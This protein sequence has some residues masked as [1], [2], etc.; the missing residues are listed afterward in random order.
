MFQHLGNVAGHI[1]MNGLG[2]LNKLFRAPFGR[3]AMLRGQ[4]L[5]VCAVTVLNTDTWMSCDLSILVID[6]NGTG[7]I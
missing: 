2:L 5:I 4:V 1:F 6:L 3:V 7:G